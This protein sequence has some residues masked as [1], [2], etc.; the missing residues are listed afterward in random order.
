MKN[1]FIVEWSRHQ[2]LHCSF[3]EVSAT[4][5][6][7]TVEQGESAPGLGAQWAE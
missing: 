6:T 4:A 1:K 2:S 7:E 5:M 3:G